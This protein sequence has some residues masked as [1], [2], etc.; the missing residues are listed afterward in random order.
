VHICYF[1]AGKSSQVVYSA[2]GLRFSLN[3][4]TLTKLNAVSSLLFF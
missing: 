4:R 2:L 3:S 1:G